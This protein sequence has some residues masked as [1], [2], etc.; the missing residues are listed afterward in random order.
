MSL[1]PQRLQFTQELIE[2]GRIQLAY[3]MAFQVPVDRYHVHGEHTSGI[4]DG[5]VA[6]DRRYNSLP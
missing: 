2:L 4:L 1:F 3:L 6:L 5:H